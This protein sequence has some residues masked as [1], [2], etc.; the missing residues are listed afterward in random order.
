[1][2]KIDDLAGSN[3]VEKIQSILINNPTCMLVSSLDMSNPSVCP[4]TVKTIEDEG[5]IWFLSD[6]H[7]EHY[8]NIREGGKVLLIFANNTDEEYLSISGDGMHY[9][10]KKVIDALWDEQDAQWYE[11]GRET[12]CIVALKVVISDAYYWDT[13]EQK[14][15]KV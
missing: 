6:K 15:V 8:K 11:N 5:A 14:T 13:T 1:M 10:E 9:D 4:M 7:S 12:D 3:A 2:E